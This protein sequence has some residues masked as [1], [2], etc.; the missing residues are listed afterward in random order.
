MFYCA[1]DEDHTKYKIHLATS[2]D[3][4]TWTRHPGNPMVVDGFDGRDP[5]ILKVGDEWVMYYTATSKPEGG[6]HTVKY[7]TSKDLD[8][9]GKSGARRSPTPRPANTAGRPSRRSS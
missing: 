4:K 5:F 8:D 6:S 1:G 7:A 2:K 9:A 3:L